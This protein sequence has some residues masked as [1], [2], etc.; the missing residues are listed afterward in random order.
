LTRPLR[1]VQ[2]R[3][4]RST[5]DRQ[6]KTRRVVKISH[7]QPLDQSR[8]GE[9]VAQMLRRAIISGELEAGTHLVESMLSERF[10]VSRAPVRE[11]LK[12]LGSEGLV[13]SRRRGVY[14]KALTEHDV[15]ELYNL[16]GMLEDAAVELA[17]NRF[18]QE[19]IAV[20]RRHLDA[21]AAAASSARVS[22]FAE[23]DMRF[24][25]AFFERAG[26]RRLLRV[27]QSFSQTFRVILEITDAGSPDLEPVVGH[28]SKILGAIE[29]RDLDEARRANAESLRYGQLVFERRLA[30]DSAAVAAFT[31]GGGGAGSTGNSPDAQS[32]S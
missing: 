12:E 23:E 17:V 21:M 30:A 19:D 18:D 1:L 11:A 7:I 10:Q 27:W 9:E 6:P 25:T 5:V 16:R 4:I 8:L 20:L 28:H 32:V 2:D 26:H 13:E 3:W 24:H 14:V 29:R 22:D 15:W 31:R